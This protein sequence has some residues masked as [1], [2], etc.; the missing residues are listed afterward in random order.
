MNQAHTGLRQD[1]AKRRQAYL[2]VTYASRVALALGSALGLL[3]VMLLYVLA[4]TYYSSDPGMMRLVS[5]MR[6]L[7]WSWG[8]FIDLASGPAPVV[9]GL[10]IAGLSGI[11]LSYS[12]ARRLKALPYVPPVAEQIA[13]LPAADILVRGSDQP[14]AAPDELLRAAREGAAPSNEELLRADTGRAR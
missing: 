11:F 12:S 14:S 6:W 10:C 5:S 3:C 13:L 8:A 2:R 4:S 9:S 1:A 7:H